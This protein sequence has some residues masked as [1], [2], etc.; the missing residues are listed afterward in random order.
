MK[1]MT[2]LRIQLTR[3]LQTYLGKTNF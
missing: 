1:T 3:L 2:V